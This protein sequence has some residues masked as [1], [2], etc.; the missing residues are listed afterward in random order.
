MKKKFFSQQKLTI[1]TSQSIIGS[2][3]Q[4]FTLFGVSFT[5]YDAERPRD[6]PVCYIR[7]PTIHCCCCAKKEVHFQVISVDGNLQTA[8]IMHQW[9]HLLLDYILSISFSFDVDVKVKS[10]IMGASFLLVNITIIYNLH[11]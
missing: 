11:N 10:L 6:Q 9:D 1:E 4:D 7:G 3:E 2:V 8:S 5:V